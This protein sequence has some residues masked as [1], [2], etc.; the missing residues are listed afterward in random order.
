MTIKEITQLR[1]SGALAEAFAQAQANLDSNPNDRF[2]KICMAWCLKDIFEQY[3]EKADVTRAVNTLDYLAGLQLDACGETLMHNRFVWDMKILL[4]KFRNT[5]QQVQV[6]S[7]LFSV[8]RYLNFVK[9]DKYYTLLLEIFAAVKTEDK[10]PWPEFLEFMQWWGFENLMP[11]DYH[12]IQLT[13]THNMPSIAERV[14]STYFKVLMAKL[15]KEE[16]KPDEVTDFLNLLTNLIDE[17][18]GFQYT[19]YQ[20]GQILLSINRKEEANAALLKFLKRKHQ[21]FWA[22]DLFADTVDDDLK[23]ACLCKALTCRADAQFL[24]KVRLKLADMM[25][26]RGFFDEART[27]IDEVIRVYS[28]H[29]WKIPAHIND[30][31]A[32][33]WYQNAQPFQ[34]NFQFYQEYAGI[35][36]ELVYSDLPET[37]IMVT[38]HNKAKNLC[39]FITGDMRRGFF[40]TN[41]FKEFFNENDIFLVRFDGDILD[42][43]ATAVL[44]LRPETEIAKYIDIFFK[45]VEGE[46]RLIPGRDFGFIEDIYVDGKLIPY[47]FESGA[48]VSGTAVRTYNI[49]KDIWGWKL[50]NLKVL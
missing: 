20:M 7:E 3:C 50:V 22:W 47:N 26:A 8:V 6:A 24:V 36:D 4:D 9:P 2:N 19:L 32:A 44:S 16:V 35:C 13:A 39:N 23:F 40:F 10:Q 30:R 45:N 18:K 15:E 38:S 42:N 41:N 48:N 1:K 27:E 11:Q 29:K 31:T 5:P 25:T 43:R 49:K 33:E 34:S 28:K 21:N 17:H 46:L 14:Y 12:T 37:A